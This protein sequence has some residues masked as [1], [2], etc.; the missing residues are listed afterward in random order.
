MGAGG[1]LGGI[2]AKDERSEPLSLYFP[3]PLPATK[4]PL[5]VEAPNAKYRLVP[6]GDIDCPIRQHRR[7]VI[8]VILFVV[9]PRPL[10]TDAFSICGGRKASQNH[11]VVLLSELLQVDLELRLTM[12]GGK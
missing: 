5:D 4:T 6:R 12:Q 2:E 7:T 11:F 8:I 1:A 9:S 3:P 10:P